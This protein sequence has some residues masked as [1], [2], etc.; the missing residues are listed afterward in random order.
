[1]KT[2]SLFS[3]NINTYILVWRKHGKI[4]GLKELLSKYRDL[5]VGFFLYKQRAISGETFTSRA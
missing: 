3:K 4:I 5:L 1:M 2:K